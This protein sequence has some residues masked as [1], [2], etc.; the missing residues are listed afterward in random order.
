[1][2]AHLTEWL[3]LGIRWLHV[4]AG[5]AWIGASFYF[6]WLEN[7]LN[8]KDN[9]RDGIAGNLWAIHGGGFYYLEKYKLA[10]AEIP[11]T[12]HWFK[13]EAYVTWL[14]GFAL[15]VVVYYLNA[16]V[17]LLNT[18]D[19][20]TGPMISEMAAI[21]IGAGSLPVGWVIY[22]VR[23]CVCLEASVNDH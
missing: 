3:N 9:L 7:A 11:K 5:I 18:A 6:N 8:R 16:Q 13:W 4:T 19:N 21:L 20:N 14:S 1:M 15:L 17:Y 2:D 10:P 23:G 12:L 22:A